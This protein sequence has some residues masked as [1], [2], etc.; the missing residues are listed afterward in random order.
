MIGG[1]TRGKGSRSPLGAILVGYWDKGKLRYA[2]HVGSGF[3]DATLAQVKSR[4]EP[5]AVKANPFT[6]KPELKR[7]GDGHWV[8]CHLRS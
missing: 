6:E 5:L 4:L 1:Y 7:C 8:A 2:S 3:D